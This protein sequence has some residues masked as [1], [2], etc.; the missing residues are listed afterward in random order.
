M[1]AVSI[2][3]IK[4]VTKHATYMIQNMAPALSLLALTKF[5]QAPG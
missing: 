4:V 3:F 1:I 5:E 2:K